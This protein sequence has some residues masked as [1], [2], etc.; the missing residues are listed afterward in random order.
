V[1]ITL[2][3]SFIDCFYMHMRAVVCVDANFVKPSGRMALLDY[4]WVGPGNSQ[5][6]T[7]NFHSRELASVIEM[8]GMWWQVS[9]YSVPMSWDAGWEK[10]DGNGRRHEDRRPPYCKMI[11]ATL[12]N[13]QTDF[14]LV[15]LVVQLASWA[16]C[17]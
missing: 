13:T 7:G 1:S 6:R 11:C 17:G 12:V 9:W 8:C 4:C 14:W 2:Y 5:S 3:N 16:K 15:V 10:R